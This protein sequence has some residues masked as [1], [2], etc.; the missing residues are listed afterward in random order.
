MLLN[1]RKFHFKAKRSG[2]HFKYLKGLMFNYFMIQFNKFIIAQRVNRNF[3]N[4][5]RFLMDEI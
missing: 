3:H 1:F 4:Q 5:Y 2:S